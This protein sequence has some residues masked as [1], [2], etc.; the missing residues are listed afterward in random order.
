[1]SGIVFYAGIGWL[2]ILL[3]AAVLRLGRAPS[4]AEK[5]LALDLLTLILVGLLALVAGEDRRAFSLDAAL[6]IALL[7]FIATLAACRYH[8]DRRPFS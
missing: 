8:E 6:A 5:I 3:G 7:G 2:A 4:T 1:M